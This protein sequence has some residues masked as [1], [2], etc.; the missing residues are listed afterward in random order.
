MSLHPWQTPLPNG[1]LRHAVYLLRSGHYVLLGDP[2]PEGISAFLVNAKVMEYVKG[3][4]MILTPKFLYTHSR[5]CW[6]AADWRRRV[7]DVAGDI[8]LENAR[9]DRIELARELDA[10]R[11]RAIDAE[12]AAQ[13]AANRRLLRLA[14]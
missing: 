7:H 10:S 8:A 4:G 2:Y 14:A 13:K 6:T 12:Y 1:L 5:L 3:G 9:R 11:A